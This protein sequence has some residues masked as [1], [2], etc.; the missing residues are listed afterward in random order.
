MAT[1]TLVFESVSQYALRLDVAGTLTYIGHA[2][3]GSVITEAV[4][5]IRRLDSSAD[6][7]LSVTW[8]DGDDLFDNIW[9][10]RTSLDYS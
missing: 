9:N 1:H 2:D 5:R 7:D 6:P 8:A 4:W 10:D 3:P